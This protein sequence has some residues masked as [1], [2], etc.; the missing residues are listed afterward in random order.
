MQ[1]TRAALLI[2]CFA[3]G[4]SAAAAQERLTVGVIERP[5]FAMQ[6]QDGAWTGMAIDLW[7]IVAEDLDVSY[8]YVAVSGPGALDGG[9]VD[10]VIPV[11][12]T[13]D[14][15]ER[16]QLSQP[17]YTAT[18]GL[19]SPTQGRVLSVVRGFASWQFARLVL[20]LSA[21]LLLVGALVW[22]LERGRNEEQFARRPMRGLGDGFWWAGVTLTTIGYGDKA[23]RTLAGR[24]VAM[25][26]MLVGLAVSAALTAS[27]VALAGLERQV[28]A[29]E[30]FAGSRVG[31]VEGGT[32]ALFLD[33]EGVDVR[34]FADVAAA[35]T[36]LDEGTVEMVAAASPALQHAVR[37][38][39]SFDFTVRTTQR[40]PHYVTAAL[41]SDSAMVEA[42][43]AAL[44]TRLTAESGW[45]VVERYLSP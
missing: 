30:A 26:W 38:D 2:L 19:A 27:V 7:R 1:M 40:D 18:M 8:E 23:P 24:A 20:G 5:P 33:R 39:G 9:D 41:P 13:P 25:L 45:E 16:F 36:A 43:D 12:A 6:T 37:E 34:L 17:F 15:S 3:L 42:L 44:L 35:L 32:A 10:L 22:L 11:Y 31:A 21:L 4:A 28:E 14:L 29:P